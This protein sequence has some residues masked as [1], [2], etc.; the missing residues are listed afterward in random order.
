VNAAFAGLLS[1]DLQDPAR[2]KLSGFKRLGKE[3]LGDVD[4]L[5]YQIETPDGRETKCKLWLSTKTGLPVKR[6]FEVS[7]GGKVILRT[8][9]SYG[10]W[11]TDFT[12][13]EGTFTLPKE[14]T[15]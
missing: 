9:E 7:E 8:S 12:P 13:P 5:Q 11:N 6:V 4:V 1:G 15:P 3:K 14:P 2:R 10:E